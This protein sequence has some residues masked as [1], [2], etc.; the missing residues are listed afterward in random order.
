MKKFCSY[1]EYVTSTEKDSKN[2]LLKIK[3]IENLETI[4]IL[5]V[6]TDMRHIV[7]VT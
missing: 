4:D 3:I 2:S 7:Y 6:N 1:Q 5:R